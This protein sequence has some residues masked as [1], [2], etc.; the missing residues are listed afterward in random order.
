MIATFVKNLFETKQPSD[1]TI[2][3]DFYDTAD[4]TIGMSE[5][6]RQNCNTG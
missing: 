2:S 6:Q 1:E 3:G 5:F 4:S